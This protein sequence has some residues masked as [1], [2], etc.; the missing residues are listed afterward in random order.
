MN[1]IVSCI[2]FGNN[3]EEREEYILPSLDQAYTN[4]LAIRSTRLSR[5]TNL[6]LCFVAP[7]T[8]WR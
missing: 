6:H 2:R 4:N 1:I 7:D 3:D 8:R 5:R